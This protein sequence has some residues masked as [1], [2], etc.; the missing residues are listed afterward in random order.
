MAKRGHSR[1]WS[2][3][4][5]SRWLSRIDRYASRPVAVVTVIAAAGVWIAISIAARFPA[6]WETVFQTVVAALTLTMVFIIQ[7]TQAR[8][9]RA[10]Q[11]KLDEIVQAIPG[12]DNSLLTFEHVSDDELSAA[13]GQHRDI[14]Q[15]AVDDP[16]A[17]GAG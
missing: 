14:R 10:T 11:R 8:Q 9:Q 16:S 1:G 13:A 4:V 15:E 3:S 2:R 12:A 7:H 6:R 17:S 5:V